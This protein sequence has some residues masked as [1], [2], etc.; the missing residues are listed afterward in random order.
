MQ[1][2]SKNK[3]KI[4]VTGSAGFIGSHILTNIDKNFFIIYATYRFNKPKKILKHVKYIKSDLANFNKFPKQ[5]EIIIHCASEVPAKCDDK[6]KLLKINTNAGIEIINYCI[7][8]NVKKFINISSMAVYGRITGRYVDENTLLKKQNYY[9]KS[10]SIIELL[11][12]KW[13][14]EF[15][16]SAF[17]LRLPGIIG[18]G[19]HSNFISNIQKNID[20]NLA[21]SAINPNSKFNN[22]VHIDTLCEFINKLIINNNV[23][24]EVFTLGSTESISIK[25]LLKYIFF[26]NGKKQSIVWKK[27]KFHDTP[28]T[29]K[30]KNSLKYGF[31]PLA[32]KE[33][34]KKYIKG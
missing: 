27:N 11:V 21:V 8:S 34:L 16:A 26:L 29:I 7:K 5:C 10:K 6:K 12:K 32:V 15:I 18:K 25:E 20:S 3:K 19:S 30:Y 1:S 22:V 31:N 28:F 13:S 33:T 4:L 9:G 24:Y 17:S 14:K 2:I 23:G